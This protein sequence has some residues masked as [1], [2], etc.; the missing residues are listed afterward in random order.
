MSCA[1]ELALARDSCFIKPKSNSV[2]VSEI[3][4]KNNIWITMMTMTITEKDLKS[5]SLQD[6]LSNQHQTN[7]SHSSN[8]TIMTKWSGLDIYNCVIG[9]NGAK[10]I[11][12]SSFLQHHQ[13]ASLCVA[14]NKI[15][16]DG[17]IAIATASSLQQLT[18]LDI[19]GNYIA[20]EGIQ[21]I[22]SSLHQL[23]NLNIAYSNLSAKEAIVIASCLHQ[24]KSLEIHGNHIGN[25]G[26][27]AIA[28]NM[29]QLTSLI[30]CHNYI[31]FEGVS[32]IAR[33]MPQLTI[34]N[35]S[36]NEIC[37]K[38]GQAIA[39]MQQLTDLNVSFCGIETEGAKAIA[40]SMHQLIHLNIS[41]NNIGSMGAQAI[42]SS[43][44]QLTHLVMFGNNIGGEGIVAI[45]LLC[46]L[47]KLG[48]EIDSI[49]GKGII[50][51]VESLPNLTSL[52]IC[53][54]QNPYSLQTIY[55]MWNKTDMEI[56]QHVQQ[57][58]SVE[59]KQFRYAQQALPRLQKEYECLIRCRHALMEL[60]ISDH[61]YD[62]ENMLTM[63]NAFALI[64]IQHVLIP[65]TLVEIR[66]QETH[67]I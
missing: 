23:T 27:E 13:L 53:I 43:L 37:T 10:I 17:I 20:S 19:A 5:Q 6:L 32:A 22:A 15:R 30:V 38:G 59:R 11:A 50:D 49:E 25:D 62:Y 36:S 45:A 16:D 61:A 1:R 44:H 66:K 67:L 64:V 12:S 39:T 24:L 33:S 31:T 63:D 54:C 47:T 65:Q 3:N 8:N 9:N 21:A 52:R 35:I 58:M 7:H 34:L 46:R 51:L 48:I 4:K 2:F 55:K 29:P 60:V 28:H 40:S 56:Y 26:V 57:N 42:G 18:S 14:Y 41:N